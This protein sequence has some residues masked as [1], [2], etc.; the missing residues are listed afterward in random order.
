MNIPKHI[1]IILDGNRRFAR[2]KNLPT[3]E[4][5]RLGF[6]NLKKIAQHAF[7]KGVK[8]LTVYA[9]STEN[10]HR[11]EKE[12]SYLLNLF[13]LLVNKEIS[14]LIK[15]G[16]KVNFFGRIGDFDSDLQKSI[17]NAREKSQNGDKGILNICLSYN[18]RDEIIRAVKKIIESGIT[19]GEVTE[20]LVN[21]NL[22]SAGLP[23][24]DMIIRTSGEQRLSGFL[25]WQSIYSEFYFPKKYWPEF[26]TA[27]FDLALEEY[28][29]RQRRYGVD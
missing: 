17:K 22:D 12:V 16:V 5:H 4:G 11:D 28:N 23:D 1:G 3:F 26:T 19:A 10:W 29:K 13:K 2:S 8:I 9:F 18:G 15:N 27:D 25:T 21:K 7:N 14:L 24:P 20:D 6:E